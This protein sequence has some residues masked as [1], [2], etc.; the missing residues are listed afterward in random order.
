MTSPATPGTGTEEDRPHRPEHNLRAAGG[1]TAIAPGLAESMQPT[2][3][4]LRMMRRKRG[5]GLGAARRE[6]RRSTTRC[7]PAAGRQRGRSAAL[8]FWAR[9]PHRTRRAAACENAS[10]RCR[11]TFAKQP[12]FSLTGAA[13]DVTLS[14]PGFA[15]AGTSPYRDHLPVSLPRRPRSPR[16]IHAL[17]DGC[18]SSPGFSSAHRAGRT[19]HTACI[20]SFPRVDPAIARA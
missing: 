5:R 3:A 1:S 18:G 2:A 11:C 16:R 7:C 15:R 17:G 20:I 4:P 19:M 6:E 14:M 10:A 13:R 12:V 8:S 9:R